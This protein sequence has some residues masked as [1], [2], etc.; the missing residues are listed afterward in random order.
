LIA[1]EGNSTMKED[2]NDD[3]TNK[4]CVGI[5]F[6]EG[7]ETLKF[8]DYYKVKNRLAKG[9]YGTV[10]V[11]EHIQSH[12]DYAVKVIERS[13]LSPKDKDLV[14]REVAIMKDCRDIENVVTLVDYFVSP[15]TFYVVQVFAEGGKKIKTT[16]RRGCYMLRFASCTSRRKFRKLTNE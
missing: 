9:S 5:S 3:K 12:K 6:D 4:T 7:G 16:H 8:T 11:T 14:A 13:R 1:K 2:N 10:F 15:D